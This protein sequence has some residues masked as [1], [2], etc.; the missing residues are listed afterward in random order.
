[1]A[2]ESSFIPSDLDTYIRMQMDFIE[3]D[4]GSIRFLRM[5]GRLYEPVAEARDA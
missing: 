1:V 3:R 4:D 2:T 5:G